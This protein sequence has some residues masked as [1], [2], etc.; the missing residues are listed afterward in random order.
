MTTTQD[1]VPHTDTPIIRASIL[2]MDDRELAEYVQL[3]HVRRLASWNIY[4]AGIEAK[5]RAQEDKDKA[6]LDKSLTR[7]L[8]LHET[9]LK[10][11]NK[12][13]QLA[14]EIQV[15]RIAIGDLG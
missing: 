10:N 1:V 15:A 3:L 6:L 5:R 9:A 13:E 12:L 14:T 7:F 2:D 4:Q 11:I 8:K